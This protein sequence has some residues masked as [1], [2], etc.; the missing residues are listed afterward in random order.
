MEILK[1]FSPAFTD[2]GP[3]PVKY[4]CKGE[5]INPPLHVRDLPSETVS[6]AIIVEDPD[7][8]SGVFDHW[9]V[10]NIPPM[11][12]IPE[13]LDKGVSGNNSKN[14]SGYTGPCPPS[15]THR[16]AFKV[17][18]LDGLLDLRAGTN[19]KELLDAMKDHILAG[20]ELVGIFSRAALEKV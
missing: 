20:G 3:M 16:Y 6:I 2:H 15:G 4:S 18:A 17:Y 12:E 14:K 7:A 11:E 13:K 9:V 8:P 10:W 1:V 19:K 5:N